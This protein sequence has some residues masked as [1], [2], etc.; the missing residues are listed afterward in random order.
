[1]ESKTPKEMEMAF[2]TLSKGTSMQEIGKTIRLRAV[3][4]IYSIIATYTPGK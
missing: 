3:G 2:A 4:P 1:M